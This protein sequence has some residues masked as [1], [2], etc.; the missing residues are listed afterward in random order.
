MLVVPHAENRPLSPDEGHK[1]RAAIRLNT[2]NKRRFHIHHLP[3]RYGALFEAARLALRSG[4]RVA[5]ADD[6]FCLLKHSASGVNRYAG[7]TMDAVMNVLNVSPAF[8]VT[9]SLGL[10][11]T[12]GTLRTAFQSRPAYTHPCRYGRLHHTSGS[13]SQRY[14][15]RGLTTPPAARGTRNP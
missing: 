6:P 2:T 5:V 3:D 12:D 7:R 14:H 8:L 1:P 10:L 4:S 15:S 9:A 11:L 13:T